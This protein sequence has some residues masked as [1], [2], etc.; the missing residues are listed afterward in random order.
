MMMLSTSALFTPKTPQGWLTQILA[1]AVTQGLSSTSWQAGDPILTVL[2]IVA[3]ELAK[4]DAYGI[5]LRA[6]GGFLDFA[7]TGSV[8]FTDDLVQP[9]KVI[10]LPVTPDPSIPSQNPTGAP[11][12]LDTLAS[13]VYNVKR[14]QATAAAGTLYLANT[15][16]VSLGSFTPGTFHVQNAFTGATYS[17]QASFTFSASAVV[18]TTVNSVAPITPVQVQFSGAHGLSTGAVV[19]CKGLQ[20]AADDFYSV[21]V[22]DSTHITL[23]GSFWT[24]A[25]WSGGG[26]VYTTQPIPF[27]ADALGPASNAGIEQIN[28]LITA[29]PKSYCG[30]LTT[31]S[32]SPWQSNASLAAQCRAKLATLSAM[33]P[34]GAYNYFALVASFILAGTPINQTPSNPAGTLLTSPIPSPM[35]LDGG[36]ITKTLVSL[37]TATGTVTTYV[38]NA[39]GPVGG[40]NLTP[41]TGASAA[42]PIVITAGGHGLVTGDWAQ[43]NGVQGLTGANGQWQVTFIDSSHV[44]LNGSSGAGTYTAGSGLISGGDVYAVGAVLQTYARP[45]AVTSL[46]QSAVATTLTVTGVVYVPSAFVGDYTTKM[47]AALQAYVTSVLPIGGLNV[48]GLSN[49]VPLGAIEGILYSAGQSNGQIY[50]LSVINVALNGVPFDLSLSPIGIATLGTLAGIT[51]IGQ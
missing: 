4:E 22:T 10:V 3:E 33:G 8:T 39:G 6:M 29:A 35:T 40:S 48:D 26:T 18:D 13:S 32:G 31:W 25:P 21:T 37:S 14:G 49:V 12:L 7:A 30:N 36:P 24:G 5:S 43:V 17:N 9:P 41:I 15:S 38:A 44:S 16:G 28:Q 51:V 1:D 50:T 20:A 42:S 34:A 27:A 45:N 47:A 46:V 19:F 23:N 11:G 2:A